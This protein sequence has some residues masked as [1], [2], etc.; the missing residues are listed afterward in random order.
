MPCSYV[1]PKDKK[2]LVLAVAVQSVAVA[3]D[4]SHQS[5]QLYRKGIHYE[6]HCSS[7]ELNP[8]VLLVGYGSKGCSPVKQIEPND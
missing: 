8:A 3:V 2:A 1:K 7:E 6:P 5:F 4:A